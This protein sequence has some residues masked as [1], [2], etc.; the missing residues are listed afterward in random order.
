VA[1]R[2]AKLRDADLALAHGLAYRGDRDLYLALPAEVVAATLTRVPWITPP[3]R[4]WSY[5]DT[6]LTE[7]VLPA[8]VE[9][10]G[11]YTDAFETSVANLGQQEKWVLALMQWAPQRVIP[12]H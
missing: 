12:S 3:L 6:E 7:E 1:R 10:L 5:T 2:S 4:I 8:P 9:V 11:S